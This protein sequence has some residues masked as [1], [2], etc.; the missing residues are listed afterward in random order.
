MTKTLRKIIEERISNLYLTSKALKDGGKKDSGF[1]GKAEML[2]SILNEFDG[3]EE[4]E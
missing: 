3:V 1:I 2:E 4:P